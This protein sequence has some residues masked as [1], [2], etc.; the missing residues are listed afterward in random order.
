MKY[1]AHSTG[2]FLR[3]VAI[4]YVRFG[5]VRYLIITVPQT[6]DLERVDRNIIKAYHITYHRTTRATR[7]KN[8]EAVVA[9]VRFGHRFV[10][11][12][13]EGRHE[14]VEKREFKDCRVTPIHLSG[15]TI[16]FKGEKVN[17][18]MSF[19]R[20]RALRKLLNRIALHNEN[21]LT[22]FFGRISPYAF[23]GIIRQELKLLKM[24]NVKRKRAGLRKI[25]PVFY[26]FDFSKIENS[27]KNKEIVKNNLVTTNS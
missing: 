18:Q 10:L 27:K 5:Y 6:K 3:K 8:G 7:K 26:S 25:Q 15:Y 1:E 21:K 13:T 16:G 2:E 20:Y 4:D 12:A 19:K 17:V 23:P 14:E 22:D 11:L 24:V 9:Y